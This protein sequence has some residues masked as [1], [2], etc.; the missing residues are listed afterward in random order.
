M[1]AAGFI[2]TSARDRRSF[3]RNERGATAVEFALI[4]LPFFSV[5]W[6]IVETGLLY[7]ADSALD[8][9]TTNAARLIRTG[10]AQAQGF[11]AAAFR[12]QVCAGVTPMLDCDG[13]KLDV[14][15]SADFAG[16]DLGSPLGAD[17]M[18]DDSQFIYEDGQGLDI[19]VVRV[20]Y[21]W[22]VNLNLL[23][24]NGTSDGTYLLAA[25]TA[26]RNEPFTW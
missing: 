8:N 6:A 15:T 2:I 21:S 4:A 17:G 12:A 9:A 26:F 10:Q 3:W 7:F 5:I 13:L 16:A 11:D 19:V 14:R 23:A 24:A 20:F 22:P 18:L 1:A 25:V